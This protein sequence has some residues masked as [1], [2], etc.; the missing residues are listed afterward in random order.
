MNSGGVEDISFQVSTV[1]RAGKT[2]ISLVG[3]KHSHHSLEALLQFYQDPKYFAQT[4]D[5]DIPV[6]LIVPQAPLRSGGGGSDDSDYSRAADVGDVYESRW[7]RGEGSNTVTTP[8]ASKDAVYGSIYDVVH[9]GSLEQKK[10][11]ERIVTASAYDVCTPYNPLDQLDQTPDV[12]FSDA[13]AAVDAHCEE[14]MVAEGKVALDFATKHEHVGTVQRTEAGA[15][16]LTAD[17]I[18][19]LHMYSRDTSFYR[20]L[21]EELG[22]YGK[23]HAHGAVSDFL[24]IA[25]LLVAALAKLP[26]MNAKLFRGV[27]M[28]FKSILGSDVK[29]KDVKQWNQV[30]SCSTRSDVLKDDDF[31]G[32]G[33]AGTVFQ[34]IA[35]TGRNIKPYS[36]IQDEDEMVLPPGSRFVIDAV[37]PCKDGVTEVRMRQLLDE[38]GGGGG[39]G[40][41]GS[42]VVYEELPFLSSKAAVEMK[43]YWLTGQTSREESEQILGDRWGGEVGTFLIR[44]SGAAFVI[45]RLGRSDAGN[46]SQQSVTMMIHR[47]IDYK[48]GMYQMQSV[49]TKAPAFKTLVGLLNTETPRPSCTL[50]LDTA[51]PV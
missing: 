44:E 23:G 18:A 35:V 24:P 50:R 6:Q 22:G 38:G 32:V 2:I 40:S 25:K 26:P 30:T 14:D 20:R 9:G 11:Y 43:P 4:V 36:A 15:M 29:V 27:K 34:I 49:R 41:G 47:K 16:P 46:S 48:A 33:N 31:L 51:Y 8:N 5:P 45:S 28:D 17:D 13:I 42:K 19:V 37:T 7:W 12:S 21:N 3:S 1:A 39:G 10:M